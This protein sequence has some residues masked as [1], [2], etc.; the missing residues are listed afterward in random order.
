MGQFLVGKHDGAG[1]GSGPRSCR[2]V[3]FLMR[4][5]QQPAVGGHEN[6]AGNDWDGMSERPISCLGAP[7]VVLTRLVHRFTG[8]SRSGHRLPSRLSARLRKRR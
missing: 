3:V 1:R 7:A 5:R 8:P 4:Q 2:F 6:I